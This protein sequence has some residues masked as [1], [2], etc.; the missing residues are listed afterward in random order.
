[1]S[2]KGNMKGKPQ[3]ERAAA[4]MPETS[5]SR[6]LQYPAWLDDFK[7]Q[8]AIVA[9]LAFILYANTAKNEY[10]LD[11]TIVIVKNEFVLEGFAGIPDILS[12]DAYYSYYRQLG[13][14]NQL[15]GGRYRAAVPHYIRYRTTVFRRHSQ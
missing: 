2:K 11:D 9:L 15:H 13:T 3:A 8:A 1:M 12:K 7:L 14:T 5:V 6:K 4:T 10:A